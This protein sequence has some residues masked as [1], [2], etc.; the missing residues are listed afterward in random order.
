MF[1]IFTL[2]VTN[3]AVAGDL[4]DVTDFDTKGKT[5]TVDYGQPIN[6]LRVSGPKDDVVWLRAFRGT[7][8]ELVAQ[9]RRFAPHCARMPHMVFPGWW[10]TDNRITFGQRFEAWALG[11]S[12]NGVY[13]NGEWVFVFDVRPAGKGGGIFQQDIELDQKIV[14]AYFDSGLEI[15]VVNNHNVRVSSGNHTN[16]VTPPTAMSIACALPEKILP[17]KLFLAGTARSGDHGLR[18]LIARLWRRPAAVVVAMKR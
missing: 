16:T 9:A 13:G 14:E 5:A 1:F 17:E 6:F 11:P 15:T 18:S 3:A 2:M 12:N 10:L 8:S 7:K 4:R